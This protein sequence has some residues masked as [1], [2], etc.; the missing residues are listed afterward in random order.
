MIVQTLFCSR[1]GNRRPGFLHPFLASLS[2]RGTLPQPRS[3]ALAISDSVSM[4]SDLSSILGRSKLSM[5]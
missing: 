3:D 5:L 4:N 1:L 2:F